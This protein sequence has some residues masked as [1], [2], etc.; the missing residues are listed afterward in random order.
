VNVDVAEGDFVQVMTAPVRPA[1]IGGRDGNYLHV[2][3]PLSSEAI[4]LVEQCRQSGDLEYALIFNVVMSPVVSH[5]GESVLGV[6]RRV[7]VRNRI[8][9]SGVQG[10]IP[11]TQWLQHLKQMGW[12][13]TDIIEIA[14]A[15]L[16]RQIPEAGRRFEEARDRFRAGDWEGTLQSC[17]SVQESVAR[18]YSPGEQRPNMKTLRDAFD[19]GEKGDHLNAVT[20]ALGEF[21]H[22]GRHESGARINRA[23]ALY[24]LQSTAAF[25]TYLG[26]REP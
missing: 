26:R 14:L 22:L 24:A 21:Y 10:R 17:R 5:S 2:T 9:N 12:Q 11:Q 6:P 25:L 18:V 19:Q 20:I 15:P 8:G 4:Y 7:L 23:D 1:T 13:D 3:I 16:A